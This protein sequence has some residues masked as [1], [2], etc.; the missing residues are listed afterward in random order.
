M[1][2]DF[3][4]AI[5]ALG[6]AAIAFGICRQRDAKSDDGQPV[7]EDEVAPFKPT[8]LDAMPRDDRKKTPRVTIRSRVVDVPESATD[9]PTDG[10]REFCLAVHGESHRNSD[11]SSRQKILRRCQV[12]EPIEPVLEPDNLYDSDAVKVC[13]ANGEQL[14]YAPAD[15][16][17]AQTIRAGRLLRVSIAELIG[18]TP[19]KPSRG[20]VLWVS[21]KP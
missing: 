15:S 6:G 17:I 8:A 20:V 21:V 2:V 10:I 13:R 14:G 11:G 16:R 4:V 9:A 18:G 1:S 7:S 12:G 19:G 3:V 5:V